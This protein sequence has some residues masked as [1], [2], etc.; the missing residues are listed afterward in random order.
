MKLKALCGD[1]G[2]YSSCLFHFTDEYQKRVL[3]HFVFSHLQF[4]FFMKVGFFVFCLWGF[5]EFVRYAIFNINE[6]V[7]MCVFFS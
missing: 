7:I 1:G 6:H 5:S 2:D 3:K 4:Y